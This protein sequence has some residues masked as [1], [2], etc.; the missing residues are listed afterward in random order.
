MAFWRCI[1]RLTEIDV[2]FHMTDVR[3]LKKRTTCRNHPP[4]N[5]PGPWIHFTLLAGKQSPH[6]WLDEKNTA[7]FPHALLITP[8]RK[9]PCGSVNILIWHASVILL[10]PFPLLFSTRF[11]LFCLAFVKRFM[12]IEWTKERGIKE[13]GIP[14]SKHDNH[15]G[16]F[17]FGGPSTPR[18]C[19]REQIRPGFL[20]LWIRLIIVKIMNQ[21]EE[22]D[23]WN[24][25]FLETIIGLY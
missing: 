18:P 22:R 25:V 21:S 20:V 10:L 15:L 5:N 14:K 11:L 6:I 8:Q 1:H 17:R 23:Q 12:N 24:D 19:F 16:S 9:R 7:W 3:W 2:F 4:S 13:R